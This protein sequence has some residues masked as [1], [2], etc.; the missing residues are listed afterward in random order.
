VVLRE[1][2]ESRG[3]AKVKRIGVAEYYKGAEFT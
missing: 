3:D 2:D 1:A